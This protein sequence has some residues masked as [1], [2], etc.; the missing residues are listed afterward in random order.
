MP[1]STCTPSSRYRQRSVPSPKRLYQGLDGLSWSAWGKWKRRSRL[2]GLLA[3]RTERV[4]RQRESCVELSTKQ[5]GEAITEISAK[6]RVGLNAQDEEKGL[7]LVSEMAKRK[8]GLDPFREQIFGALALRSGLLAEMG[9]GE[10]KTL[11]IGLAAVL[12]GWRGRPV[13]IVTANDYLAARDAAELKPLYAACGLSVG[14][15]DGEMS[16]DVRRIHY[17]RSVTYG[18]SKEIVADFLKDRLALRG[19]KQG[20]ELSIDGLL[21]A[22]NE[23]LSDE[24]VETVQ[25][26]LFSAIVDEADHVLIDEAVTPLLIS[27]P[28]ENEFLQAAVEAAG[29]AISD[30]EKGIDYTVDLKRSEVELT[31]QGRKRLEALP[32]EACLM[33]RNSRW[34]SEW[35]RQA[36]RARELFLRGKHYIVVDGKVVI[37]DEATG[38]PAPMRTWRQGLHQAIE[39]KEGLALTAP[40]DNLASLS[41]QRFFRLYPKL[42]GTSGTAAENAAELWKIYHLPVVLVPPH[43]PCMRKVERETITATAAEKWEAVVADIEAKHAAGRP[44]LVGCGSVGAS[45]ELAIRLKECGHFFSLLNASQLG[46]EAEI[47]AEAGR[48]GCITV[49]T[50]MAGRGT[51]I[52]LGEGVAEAGG[53]HVIATERAS[54]ARI[55]RQLFGRCARQGDPGS[56]RQFCCLEDDLA[57]RFLPKSVVWLARKAAFFPVGILRRSALVWAQKRASKTLFRQ[58]LGVLKQ[59]Q[60]LLKN[61]PISGGSADDQV[62]ER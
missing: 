61:L 33:F 5:L 48:S 24:S 30:W 36:I 57:K 14:H 4:M 52:R 3:E 23:E 17:G 62:R 11:T 45:E 31:S 25:R 21:S 2:K 38:R 41:F 59:D 55:D 6:A 1:A 28:R 51:D 29:E 19:R 46:K 54:S 26:G 10:G 50:N 56:V 43:K 42:A 20:N 12:E 35:V 7:S 58:R 49:A 27:Q 32:P 13:H 39:S 9:T 40:S 47:V 60:W 37:V 15:I 22:S 53:L 18:T 44:V 34:K 8:L 16:A